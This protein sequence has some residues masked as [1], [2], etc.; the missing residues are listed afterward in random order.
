MPVQLGGINVS[1]GLDFRKFAAGL[2]NASVSVDSFLKRMKS[3]K[4]E[5]VIT[6]N[7]FSAT[8]KYMREASAN[9]DKVFKTWERNI[10]TVRN[11]LGKFAEGSKTSTQSLI[12][13]FNKLSERIQVL[14]TLTPSAVRSVLRKDLLVNIPTGQSGIGKYAKL[15]ESVS[16]EEQKEAFVKALRAIK[17]HIPETRD[18]VDKFLE[19]FK[20]KNLD[21]VYL[22]RK[23][24]NEFFRGLRQAH[25]EASEAVTKEYERFGKRIQREIFKQR[26]LATAEAL[27][28]AKSILPL[29]EER[30]KRLQ[31]L[32]IARKK[33]T[34]AVQAGINVDSN[35]A[36]LMKNL[37]QWERMGKTLTEEQINLYKRLYVETNKIAKF[38]GIRKAQYEAELQLAGS[39]QEA[40]KRRAEIL[41][42][43]NIEEAK[44]RTNIKMNIDVQ[45]SRIALGRL[46]ERRQQMGI[47]LS[48]EQ[49]KELRRYRMEAD[50]ARASADQL[51]SPRWFRLRA[52]WFVQLRGFWAIWR[53]LTDAMREAFSF[54]QEMAN[55]RAIAQVTDEQFK[56]LKER[57]LE[58]GKTTR[59]SATEAAKGMVKMAQAGLSSEEIFSAI[60]DTAM[61]ATATLFDF[62]RTAELITTVMRA[63]NKSASDVKEITDVLATSINESRLTMRGLATAFNYI[64]GLAPQMNLSLQETT[65]LLGLMVNR[66]LS[67]STA[68]TSLR[69]LLA[70]LLRPT[71]RFR[72]EIRDLGLTMDQVNPE[73]HS[74][75]TILKTLK[76]AG[77]GASES[78]RAFRR[79]A[80]AGATILVQTADS[81]EEMAE[82]MYQ[83]NRAMVMAQT[84]L[85][86]MSGQWKQTKD[87]L[88]ASASTILDDLEPAIRLLIEATKG[89]IIAATPLARILAAPFKGYALLINLSRELMGSK[90]EFIAALANEQ[91]ALKDT[92]DKI[93]GV[94]NEYRILRDSWQDYLD[95]LKGSKVLGKEDLYERALKIAKGLKLISNTE[96]ETIKDRTKI[97]ALIRERFEERRH[98]LALRLSRAEWAERTQ[99][100]KSVYFVRDEIKNTMDEISKLTEKVEEKKIVLKGE[101][102]GELAGEEIEEN[103]E[104][105]KEQIEDKTKY[106]RTLFFML[107]PKQQ[108]EIKKYVADVVKFTGDEVEK[109]VSRAPEKAIIKLEELAGPGKEAKEW[110]KLTTEQ[111]LARKRLQREILNEE[112][113]AIRAEIQK[114]MR[115]EMTIDNM[116]ELNILTDRLARKQYEIAEIEKKIR[117]EQSKEK[118]DRG[119]LLELSRKRYESSLRTADEERESLLERIKLARLRLELS[120]IDAEIN[121]KRVEL[122]RR[123]YL[124]ERDEPSNRKALLSID[125]DLEK[126]EEERLKRHKEIE[127][128]QVEIERLRER[129][130]Q[131]QTRLLELEERRKRIT[132]GFYD[133]MQKIKRTQRDLQQV[134]SDA[135]VAGYRVGSEGFGDLIQKATGGFQEQ[136][137]EAAN[138]RVELERLNREYQNAMSEGNI[139]RARELADEM[140]RIGA[141]IA[142][143]EDPLR[144]LGDAFRQW[145][146]DV[147]DNIRQV[148]NEWIA[149]QAMM[150]LQGLLK[151]LLGGG[152]GIGKEAAA[153]SVPFGGST[154]GVGATGGVFPEIKAFRAFSQGGLTGRPTLALLGDNRSKQEIVI[155]TENIEQNRVSGYMRPADSQQPINI[156]NVLTKEDIL[157]SIAGL[158]GQRLIVNT[159]GKDL[160]NK[161]VV[162]KSLRV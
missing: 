153:W 46:L 17:K 138:L 98:A 58:V 76:E 143:I 113:R 78:F 48:R 63:W 5:G 83:T 115:Q 11:S 116:E 6:G 162:Y 41:R 64:T 1:V 156:V 16:T 103:I 3:I 53:G 56:M 39:T 18:V 140:N 122:E 161:G 9:V 134:I 70:A 85:D 4:L 65:A 160:Q 49:R 93:R 117:D 7:P 14:K 81:F 71:A 119:A 37:A 133:A 77:W 158:E 146:K 13:D 87:I 55:V 95:A 66:G 118:E 79:R 38:G 2:Q 89:L 73:Y 20:S 99:L 92:K 144:N 94:V 59:F 42:R 125:M 114:H 90:K 150:G 28:Q 12:N 105:L 82:N 43:L 80:A 108:E 107:T 149:A 52:R 128:R 120:K 102:V 25:K 8:N 84:N 96:I 24:W 74:L 131:H 61:L 45:Q 33:L 91:L 67:F 57:A 40:I 23:A 109:A 152:G 159:I 10:N 145:A 26:G 104:D 69:A 68:A 60:K 135:L 54:E 137:Q 130:I 51:F 155:P 21:T 27:R 97:E 29:L 111:L 15:S 34:T 101:F 106:I 110:G 129:E 139:Q 30:R 142:K 126:L 62:E 157:Q 121:S 31:E 148:I 32:I 151:N 19:K 75:A 44:L 47:T 127:T 88:V 154:V 132:D 141:E 35:R 136:Q 50:R 86:T 124:I 112:S 123:R 72:R 147:I 36:L 22:V 100:L